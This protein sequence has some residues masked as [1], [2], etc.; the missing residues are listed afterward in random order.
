MLVDYRWKFKQFIS[1][2]RAFTI[3]L[4]Y[5]YILSIALIALHM[6]SRVLKAS[7]IFPFSL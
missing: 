3:D 2:L 1:L 6:L 5:V 4:N 7:E